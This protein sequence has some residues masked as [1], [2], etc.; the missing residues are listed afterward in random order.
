[1]NK[2]IKYFWYIVKHKW[3]VMIECFKRGLI[4][5]GVAHDLSKFLP[6][7]FIPYAKYFY[8][9]KLEKNCYNCNRNIGVQ[10][11]IN[12][13]GLGDGR[14]AITCSGF[15]AK[16]EYRFN[17]A[18]LKHIHRNPHHWQYWILLNDNG[19]GNLIFSDLSPLI[20]KRNKYKIVEKDK[21][22]GYWNED[23]SRFHII[24][25]E[26]LTKLYIEVLNSISVLS[27]LSV[28][29]MP[30]KYRIEM[31][32]DWIGAGKAITGK[33][34]IEEWFMENEVDIIMGYETRAKVSNEIYREKE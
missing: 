2:Y 15:I 31:I 20:N 7:E 24:C 17:I 34:N 1:M 5:R 14:Q 10:C 26:Q 18:W 9:K 4:W 29:E 32:C 22:Q 21:I 16:N 6:D 11:S 30:K 13:A 19:K 25:P 28:F 12:Y 27:R 8:G 3:Y 23:E 33:N